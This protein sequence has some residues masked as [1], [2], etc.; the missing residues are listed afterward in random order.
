MTIAIT[1]HHVGARNACTAF[2]HLAADGIH[3]VAV[4]VIAHTK[5]LVVRVNQLLQLCLVRQGI[6]LNPLMHFVNAQ[7]AVVDGAAI[8]Q[9][10]PDEGFANVGLATGHIGMRPVTVDHGQVDI[11]NM[12]VGVDVGTGKF[13]QQ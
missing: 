8:V 7:L 4:D 1:Q 10:A 13:G 9:R 11:A 12:T 5:V 3:G 6:A 2:A